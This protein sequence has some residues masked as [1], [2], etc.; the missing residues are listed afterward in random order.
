M[1]KSILL[2]CTILLIS[3]AMNAQR[4]I[5]D[6]WANKINPV[7]EKLDKSKVPFGI[8]QDF[9]MDFTDISAFNGRITDSTQMNIDRF[10]QI[11]KTLVMGNLSQDTAHFKKMKDIANVWATK[12]LEENKADR[13]ISTIVLGGL[14]YKYSKIKPNA[15][16]DKKLNSTG[17]GYE[18]AYDEDGKWQNPYEVKETLAITAPINHID[19]QEF[20]VMLPDKLFLSNIEEDVEQISINFED[21]KGF[22]DLDLNQKIRVNYFST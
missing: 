4:Q 19:Q 18:D 2:T 12:R 21:G 15:L 7:F 8:L 17:A 22:Q 9:A 5:N 20:D 1:K 3:T 14:Y 11:Y 13:T 10:S 6:D 16:A